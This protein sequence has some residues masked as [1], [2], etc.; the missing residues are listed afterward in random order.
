MYILQKTRSNLVNS[1][2]GS[3]ISDLQTPIGGHH[4][5]LY[6]TTQITEKYSTAM[7]QCQTSY[8]RPTLPQLFSFL[9]PPLGRS[10]LVTW[11][12]QEHCQCRRGSKY[13]GNA[14]TY[15]RKVQLINIGKRQQVCKT[16]LDC[17]ALSAE[18]FCLH[19]WIGPTAH[20]HYMLQINVLILSTLY[21]SVHCTV[22]TS[23]PQ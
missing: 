17:N 8:Q 14:A 19:S 2:L 15:R 23:G 16:Q 12:Y 21:L 1:G 13:F 6:F 20:K 18:L 9:V 22:Q 10:Y 11:M 3:L 5:V 4:P 7:C